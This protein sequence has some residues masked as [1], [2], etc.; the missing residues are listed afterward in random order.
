[1]GS[2]L[3]KIILS[4]VDK[5]DTKYIEEYAYNR[6]C[7]FN[8]PQSKDYVDKVVSM[9]N[10]M[11]LNVIDKRSTHNYVKVKDGSEYIRLNLIEDDVNGSKGDINSLDITIKVYKEIISPT[12][13]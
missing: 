3:V 12:N 6:F 5:I 2:K 9:A 10:E 7:I 13:N 1:M 11:G 8:A 4:I